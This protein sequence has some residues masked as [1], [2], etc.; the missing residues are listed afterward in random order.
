M[1]LQAITGTPYQVRPRG[2]T[3]QTGEYREG[4]PLAA[5]LKAERF[6]CSWRA[7]PASAAIPLGNATLPQEQP[8][9]NHH[10]L[11]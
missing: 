3:N 8:T 10:P 7:V 6:R 9:R 2:K 1:K 4:L 11:R 5:R